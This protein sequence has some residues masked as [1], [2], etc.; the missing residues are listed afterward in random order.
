MKSGHCL[1]L[2]TA[3]SAPSS[4]PGSQCLPC[5]WV[6]LLTLNSFFPS[7]PSRLS[8]EST[9]QVQICLN[10]KSGPDEEII[11]LEIFPCPK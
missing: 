7:T 1:P 3:L 2:A 8:H 5:V 9:Q 10:S 6:M 11:F 4:V